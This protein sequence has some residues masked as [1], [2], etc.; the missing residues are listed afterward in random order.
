MSLGV[1]I[2]SPTALLSLFPNSLPTSSSSDYSA[3][4][5]PVSRYSSRGNISLCHDVTLVR[6]F[7]IVKKGIPAYLNQAFDLMTDVVLGEVGVILSPGEVSH[8]L[9]GQLVLDV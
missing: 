7:V 1:K 2:Y 9:S 8:R 6:F 4:S 3:S 5:P